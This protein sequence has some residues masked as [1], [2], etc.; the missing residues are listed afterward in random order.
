MII[1]WVHT[2]HGLSKSIFALLSEH[3]VFMK[4]FFSFEHNAEMIG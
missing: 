2:V 3:I 4:V 1:R